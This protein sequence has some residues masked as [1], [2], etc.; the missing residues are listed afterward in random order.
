MTFANQVAMLSHG[1]SE[2]AKTHS[3]DII[4]NAMAALADKLNVKGDSLTTKMLTYSEKMVIAYY[5]ANKV[6]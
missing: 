1:L 5:H 6:K 3:N 2:M 4:S